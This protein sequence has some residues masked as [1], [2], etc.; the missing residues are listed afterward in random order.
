MSEA[1]SAIIKK[2]DCAQQELRPPL[3]SSQ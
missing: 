2:Q 3:R 1:I